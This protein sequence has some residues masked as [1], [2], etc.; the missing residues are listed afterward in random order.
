MDTTMYI[1]TEND[2]LSFLYR[3]DIM[4]GYYDPPGVSFSENGLANVKADVGE[5]LCDEHETITPHDPDEDGETIENIESGNETS[6]ETSGETVE[7]EETA[8]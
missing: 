8:E 2:D 5:I 6:E 4:D 3:E 7:E 1:K